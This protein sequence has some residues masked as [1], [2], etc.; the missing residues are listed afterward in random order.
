MYVSI[1]LIRSPRAMK[2]VLCAVLMLLVLS[3]CTAEMN[4]MTAGEKGHAEIAAKASET[5][6]A[7]PSYDPCHNGYHKGPP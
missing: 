2:I 5:C 6:A 3:N 7:T 4:P 1:R